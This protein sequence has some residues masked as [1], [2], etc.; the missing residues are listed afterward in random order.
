MANIIQEHKIIDNNKRALIKYTMT[1]D[2]AVANTTLLDASNLRFALNA[3]GFIMTSN[4]DP[5]SSYGLAVRRIYGT[6]KANTYVKLQWEGASNSDIVILGNGR[7]S[8]DLDTFG[9]V[10]TIPNP[11]ANATG[12]ILMTVVSPS[13]SDMMTLFI[14]VRKIAA[15]YDAGQTADPVAFNRGPAA[16]Q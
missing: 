11:E 1:L 8:F 10:A 15:D 16:F 5:K 12:D 9:D 4:T 2:T 6:A 13:A 14:D 7:F 3:N